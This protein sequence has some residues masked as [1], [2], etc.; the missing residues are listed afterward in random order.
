M[1][2]EKYGQRKVWNKIFRNRNKATG[3]RYFYQLALERIRPGDTIC[4]AG[5][6]Y[7]F[8]LPDLMRRCAPNGLFIGIDF[9][10]VALTQSIKLANGYPDAHLALAD[11][12]HLPF[13]D[14]SVDRI[15]CSETL[16]YLLGDVER[17]LQELARV[18]RR[19][20]IFSLHTRGTYEIKGTRTEFRNNI[21]I[22]HKP[23]AKPPR[24]I[25]DKE[26]ILKLIENTGGLKLEIMQ[27]LRWGELYEV[28]DEM[29]WPWYLPSMERIALYYVSAIKK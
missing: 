25:F 13:P 6:G 29:E 10:S 18:A 16:P 19:E 11:M 2:S 7:T 3:G 4:D 23:G 28:P 27:P 5:C 1:T 9:S 21:V 24:R 20:V 17:A 26:E 8:Y 15:F 14:N 12:L 22:E